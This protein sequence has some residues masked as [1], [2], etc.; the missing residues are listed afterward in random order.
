LIIGTASVGGAAVLSGRVRWP[1]TAT[2]GPG[3]AAIVSILREQLHYLDLSQIDLAAFAREF[4][5]RAG[6]SV[7]A[8]W[9]RDP[10]QF[11][12]TLTT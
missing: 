1:K 5:S 7:L 4:Q 11:S 3:S 2:A 12:Y 8:S 10:N 9:Q 6:R